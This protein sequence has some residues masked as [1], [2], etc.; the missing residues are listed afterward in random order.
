MREREYKEFNEGLNSKVKLSLY[1]SFCKEIEFKNYL[2]GV[3][4][5]GARLM[6]KFRS[7]TN[8]LNEELGRHRG[9]NDDRQCKLCGEEC[10]SVVHV[11]WECPVYDT[12]RNTFMGKLKNLLGGILKNLV[13][14]IMLKKRGLFWGVRIGTG[15]ILRLC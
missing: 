4:D 14:L 11:L 7:G 3:G 6:F 5:P 15:V 12:I 1:K 8:G 13:H 9:R 10:E 2:Q